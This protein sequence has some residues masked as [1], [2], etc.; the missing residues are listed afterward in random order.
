[1]PYALGEGQLFLQR[2]QLAATHERLQA[3]LAIVQR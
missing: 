1:M 3:A 2:N